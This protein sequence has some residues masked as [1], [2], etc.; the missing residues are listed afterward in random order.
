MVAKI[1]FENGLAVVSEILQTI[2]SRMVFLTSRSSM[3]T[4]VPFWSEG[5]ELLTCV[6]S[7]VRRG[8]REYLGGVGF[9]ILIVFGAMFC[10]AGFMF[11]GVN[12]NLYLV[13]SSTSLDCVVEHRLRGNQKLPCRK[14]DQ[15]KVEIKRG[16]GFAPV[17]IGVVTEKV[18]GEIR[19]ISW[20]TGEVLYG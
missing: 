11:D 18:K 14:E 12:T 1:I 7:N 17:M 3:T 8:G 13:S 5:T 19:P 6:T 2:R 20:A 9:C 4:Q 10:R 16:V 15:R